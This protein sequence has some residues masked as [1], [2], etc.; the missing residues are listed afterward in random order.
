[1]KNHVNA[2]TERTYYL[3]GDP[4]K[5][6]LTHDEFNYL[7]RPFWQQRK[8]LQ[9]AGECNSPGW[10]VCACDC[11]DCPYRRYGNTIDL[12]TLEDL[13]IEIADP[14]NL[15]EDVAD[16]LFRQQ[17]CRCL[18]QLDVID[19]I[20]IRAYVLH[21]TELTERECAALISKAIGRNYSHQAVHKRVPEAAKRLAKLVGYEY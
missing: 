8:A 16:R 19:Q 11:A 20:I 10:H 13:G 7:M 5:T 9:R 21:D 14:F 15:E 2:S 3:P 12:D 18:P 1:M 17:L 6:P 4:N